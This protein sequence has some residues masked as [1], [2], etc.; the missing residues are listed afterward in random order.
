MRRITVIAAGLL[1]LVG[2][3]M[4]WAAPSQQA[5]LFELFILEAR[6]D[7]ELL[8]DTVRGEDNRP[9]SW[10]FNTD[11]Q[12][13]TVV[14]DLWFDNE[15]LADEIFGVGQRPPDWF[16]ATTNDPQLLA[17]NVRHDMEL[18]ADNVFSTRQRPEAWHG[19]PP[20]Y[21]CNRTLQNLVRL[22]DQFHNTRP[23]TSLAVIDYCAAVSH[24]IEESMLQVV[25]EAA[26]EA[27]LPEL[28]LALRGDLERLANEL[29][30]V[31]QRTSGWIGNIEEGSPTLAAD[32]AADLE[33]LADEA[34]GSQ[35][36][37]EEWNRFTPTSVA[38][39]YRNLR[40]NLE[41]LADLSMGVGI[42]PHGWQGE[43]PLS[44]CDT[45]QQGLIFV[46]Q[47]RYG[48]VVDEALT[49]SPD[50][51]DLAAFTANSIAEN[52]PVLAFEDD[53]I[54]EVSRY[55]A[56]S[57][58]AFTYM[59][60]AALDYMGIMPQG[61][62]FRAWY[63]NFA[64]SNMMFVSGDD[65]ALFIDRRWTTMPEEVFASLPTL[66]GVRPLTFCDARWCNGP[67]P[68][69]TPTGSGA[70]MALVF[71][72][73]PPATIS[74]E[75]VGRVEG[76]LQV[77]WNN[78][79]VTYLLDRPETGTVQV[80]LE[81]CAEPQQIACEPVVSVFDN[82]TGT[83]KPVLSQYNGLNVYEFRYGFNDQVVVEGT[84][85]VTSA[86]FLSDPTIR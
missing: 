22:L 36:R 61:T 70:L 4:V 19:A 6:S 62:V 16:G 59:D 71:E 86:I 11:L 43:D 48:F 41:L 46:V 68:T 57:V 54:A 26:P 80:A 63:R 30:G 29:L 12:S 5:S 72:A 3:V 20:I 78:I 33:L 51:C 15:Q 58:W 45:I 75:E 53:E 50:F 76:K 77:S 23:T 42:R 60:V 10:T 40:F 34:L 35:V 37:P 27:E 38:L 17:R 9:E 31:N 49:I 2:A 47:R 13:G 8:A 74:A 82:A 67:G 73:T 84:T 28:V 14:V 66:D 55:L 81:I 83:F 65:F 24:E 44:R 64:E 39:A 7:L 21:T 25:F 69:P 85:R 56:E 1:A 32:I 18:S 79:R 52:P